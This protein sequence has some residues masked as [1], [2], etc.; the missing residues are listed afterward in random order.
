MDLEIR[1]ARL[2]DA[3]GLNAVYNP[4]IRDSA[5]T[6]E[7]IEYTREDRVRWLD[8]QASSPRWPVFVGLD[9]EGRVCGFAS[10]C[11]FDPRGAYETSVKTSVFLEPACHG[12]GLAKALYRTLFEAIERTDLHRAYALIVAPNPSSVALHR[13][14]GFDHVATLSEVGCKFGRYYDVTWLEKRL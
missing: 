2:D 6:F 4:Y 8:R 11:P 12:K 1:P 5:A 10:A 7:T 3:E 9:P 13:Q 14:F